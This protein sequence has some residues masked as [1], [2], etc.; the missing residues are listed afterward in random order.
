FTNSSFI[1]SLTAYDTFIANANPDL[2]SFDSYSFTD[3]GVLVPPRNWLGKANEFRRAALGSY[4]GYG[5]NAPRP[6]GSYLQTY[7]SGGT[8]KARDPSELEMRWQ[9]FSMLTMGFTVLNA[10][11][12]GGGNTSLFQAG[13]QSLP[14]QPYYD[15]FKES[16][17]QSL[18]LSPAL[19]RLISYS[20]N[21]NS[22]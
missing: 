16:A 8:E 11:T 9:Q 4:I 14:N 17:R 3:G 5:T 21:T 6:Y 18:N 13:N 12:A 22:S 7:H 2:V 19:T 1:N 15:N 20:N 10:F